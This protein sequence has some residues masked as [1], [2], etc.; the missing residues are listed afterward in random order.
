MR[1]GK[2]AEIILALISKNGRQIVA[3]CSDQAI[4]AGIRPGMDYRMACSIA[5][6]AFAATYNPEGDFKALYRLALWSLKIS[7]LVGFEREL[8]EAF[9]ANYFYS[10][11]PLY[12][13]III[14]LFGTE[15]IYR[16]RRSLALKILRCFYKKGFNLKIAIA[17]TIGGAWALSRFYHKSFI[18]VNTKEDL[19]RAI[20][21]L[22]LE[23][24]RI[25]SEAAETLREVGINTVSDLTKVP[26][27]EISA[28]FGYSILKK[29]DQAR[30]I[31]DETFFII[32][33]E[34][35]FS[36]EKCFDLPLHNREQL[37]KIILGLIPRLTEKIVYEKK[38]AACLLI[39]I[40]ENTQKLIPLKINFRPY[41]KDIKQ[42]SDIIYPL[43]D[44]LPITG[45][46]KKIKIKARGIYP[47]YP[48]QCSLFELKQQEETDSY[49]TELL[50]AAA[51]R[52][53]I[54]KATTASSYIP[55][56]SFSYTKLLSMDNSSD[57]LHPVKTQHSCTLPALL[58]KPLPIKT[59]K[60][61]STQ[62]PQEILVNGRR[63]KITAAS[64]P[65]RV[66]LEWWREKPS[67]TKEQR[68]YF[69]LCDNSGQ[70][71][72]LYRKRCRWFI[73][74]IWC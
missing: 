40:Y 58:L 5:P 28:R 32:H 44:N 35:Y 1:R 16:D 60:L 15:R 56:R 62:F 63:I 4:S 20:S 8:F 45:K 11:S 59:V 43:I 49:L 39:Q 66:S 50:G 21:G 25:D 33:P 38:T 17:P 42:L 22:P 73:Q 51:G 2:H 74:G 31:I 55:E 48:P 41:H 37:K 36:I 10:L 61:D 30:G 53:N 64:Q 72:W 54:F 26:A 69:S 52:Q 9:H 67:G 70:W 57:K 6:E 34:H 47:L 14:D 7:P 12:N 19:Q 27:S 13:G 18:C 46:I 24:L 29:I 65:E 3:R 23:S 68:E 71:L